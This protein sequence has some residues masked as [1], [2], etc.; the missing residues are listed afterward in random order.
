MAKTYSSR[1]PNERLRMRSINL[2]APTNLDVER[3][4]YLAVLLVFSEPALAVEDVGFLVDGVHNLDAVEE[5]GGRQERVVVTYANLVELAQV[6]GLQLEDVKLR[7][8]NDDTYSVCTLAIQTCSYLYQTK[9]H[10]AIGAK[11]VAILRTVDVREHEI[12]P[13]CAQI[14]PCLFQNRRV[15]VHHCRLDYHRC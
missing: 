8:T 11:L 14:Y 4:I 13:D 9:L 15:F 10:V 12:L 3:A 7:R 6:N 2:A 1:P 5:P